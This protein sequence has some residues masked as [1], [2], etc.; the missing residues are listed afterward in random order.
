MKWFCIGT[1]FLLVIFMIK[2]LLYRRQI[3]EICR[4]LEFM[5][6]E[7]TNKRIR[8]DLSKKEIINLA[9]K[10][11]RMVDRQEEESLSIKS[12]EQQLK[13]TLANISHDIRTPLTS[14]KGFFE[15]YT[16]EGEPEKKEYFEQVIREKM[17]DLTVLLEELFTY[18]KLQNETYE[19]HLMKQDFTKLVLDSLFS[20]YGQW[21]EKG[22][23]PILSVDEDTIMVLCN[24][25]AV[26]RILTN[27]LRNAMLHGDGNIE[28]CYQVKKD[29]VLF[30]CCN[31]FQ[32]AG[33][34][35][36]E[37]VFER[38]YK[39]DSARR[40]TSSGLGLSIA[41][42]LALRMD[43]SMEARTED[44]RFLVELVFPRAGAGLFFVG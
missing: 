5:Q 24:D 38:F 36:M 18:T 33:E 31:G 7:T 14:M 23:S 42:E 20:F 19:L 4:Q 37:R 2:Y 12:K 39:G 44:G 21:K 35:D 28:I 41:K 29:G 9:G 25:T 8:T 3:H 43:G 40:E 13:E 26:R 27:V 15:L 34:P 17:D 10:I 16:Q 1:V 11:N 32:S 22:I 30:R 6:K